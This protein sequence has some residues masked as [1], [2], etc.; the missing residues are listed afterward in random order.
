M[1]NQQRRPGAAESRPAF[2]SAVTPGRLLE[3]SFKGMDLSAQTP[4]FCLSPVPPSVG[5]LDRFVIVP[6]V[7]LVRL[8]DVVRPIEAIEPILF[9][10]LG[11]GRGRRKK[12]RINV[13]RNTPTS[14]RIS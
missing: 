1:P 4:Q 5:H 6:G 14:T 2:L 11:E 12:R 13:Q 7:K 3:R 10:S 8:G 9:S